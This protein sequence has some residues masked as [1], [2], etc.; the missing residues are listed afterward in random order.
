M[1]DWLREFYDDVDNG[2]IDSLAERC[3]EDLSFQVG[4][5]SPINGRAAVMEAERQFLTSITS[6]SH[7][8]INVFN[9]EDTT[10][11]EAV[12]TYIRVDGTAVDVPCTSILHRSDELVDSIRVYLDITPVY[13]PA[14]AL[15]NVSNESVR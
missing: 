8:F 9:D 6:H 14:V 1:A 12:V 15:N 11:M 7:R 3:T 2:R 5:M 13:A 10:V 4:G